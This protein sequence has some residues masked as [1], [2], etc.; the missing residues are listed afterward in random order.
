VITK[1]KTKRAVKKAASVSKKRPTVGARIVELTGL[2]D[3]EG[4]A[5]LAAD[6][7]AGL[8]G[9][10]PVAIVSLPKRA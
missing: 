5:A 2:L 4:A 7:V 9:D 6:D 1:T 8:P 10:E 3:G